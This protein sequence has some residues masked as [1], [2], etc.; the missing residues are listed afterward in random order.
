MILFVAKRGQ[1]S[2]DSKTSSF[3]TAKI[4]LV[5]NPSLPQ[6]QI[7]FQA[8]LYHFCNHPRPPFAPSFTLALESHDIAGPDTRN[9]AR[10][11]EPPS[12]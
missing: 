10:H 12:T 4:L 9:N 2:F 1:T 3:R 6:Q 7:D 5:D 8:T 11:L